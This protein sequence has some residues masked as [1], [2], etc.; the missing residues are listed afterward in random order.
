[1]ALPSVIASTNESATRAS[2]TPRF[3]NS[4][5]VLASVS[6]ACSTSGGG[7]SLALPSSSE[8]IHQVTT[9]NATDSRRIA[10]LPRYGA[11]ERAGIELRRGPDEIPTADLRQHPVEH[12]RIFL[13]FGDGPA[14]DSL[15]V[16]VT[17]G[18]QRG[19][20]GGAGQGLNPVPLRVRG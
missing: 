18:V 19:G 10:S 15:A 9:N 8:A 4:A 16:A 12:T 1:M 13:L 5:P 3:R 6:I 17:I 2:V 7:G 20:I 11:I 14:R